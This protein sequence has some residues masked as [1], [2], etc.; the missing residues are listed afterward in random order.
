M[1]FDMI[2]RSCSKVYSVHG[3]ERIV[4]ASKEELIIRCL[5]SLIRSATFAHQKYQADSFS[6]TIIDDHSSESCVRAIQ[7]A[8]S[9]VAFPTRFI[10]MTDRTGN[11][12]SLLTTYEYARDNCEDLIYFVEDD[13]LHESI[14]VPEL[15][16]S[17]ATISNTVKS[18]VVLYPC[19]YL[20]LY[21]KHYPSAILLSRDRYWRN[22]GH[23]TGTIVVSKKTLTRYWDRF[24]DFTRYDIDPDISEENTLNQIYRNGGVPCFSPMPSLAVHM[25]PEACAS[26]FVN[27]R[28][29]WDENAP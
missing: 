4:N 24:M 23:T 10:S 2:F 9:E 18:D 14:A 19:D 16:S 28:K 15:L 5:R 27:W 22:I 25:G 17:Y 7:I 26:P 21:Q 20:T 13:F 11:G 8:L 29:W 6:L 3:G 12:Q 1:R